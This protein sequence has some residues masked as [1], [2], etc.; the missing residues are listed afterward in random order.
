MT[1]LPITRNKLMIKYNEHQFYFEEDEIVTEYPLTIFLNDQ[2]FATLVCTPSDLEELII[3]FLA[4]E[5][6]IRSYQEIKDIMINPNHG[7]AYVDLNRP[8]QLNQQFFS[9]RRITSCCGKSRQSF[10]FFNDA[11][12][13]KPVQSSTNITPSDCFRLMDYLQKS[14]TLHQITGGVHNAALCTPEQIVVRYSDIGRHNA[15]DKIFGHCLKMGIATEDKILVFSG[16]ISS[17][18]LLKA[19]KIG[20]GVVLSKSAPTTLS[21]QLAEELGITIIGFIR[22]NRLNIYTHTE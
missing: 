12:T 9:K 11:R 19:A 6:A 20:V 10:Y 17:E 15:L 16:R 5:G 2:E 13:A 21:L 8:F 22:D 1:N 7:I 14:S 18:I 4:S 3:G